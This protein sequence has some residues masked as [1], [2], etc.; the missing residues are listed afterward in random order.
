VLACNLEGIMKVF[1]LYTRGYLKTI[2]FDDVVDLFSSKCDLLMNL[3]DITYC[4]GLSK[5]TVA[6]EN[7]EKESEKY[8]KL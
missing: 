3:K 7:D 5:M 2:T 1:N 8:Q 6:L 4:Y